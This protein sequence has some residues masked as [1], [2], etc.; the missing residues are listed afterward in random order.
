VTLPLSPNHGPKQWKRPVLL[1]NAGSRS[2]PALIDLT[3]STLETLGLPLLA[4]EL[5]EGHALVER[6]RHWMNDGADLLIVGGGDGTLR[7]TAEEMR[8]GET[9]LGILPLGTGNNFAR[10]LGL[11]IDLAGACKALVRG[12]TRTIELGE[13]EFD[14]GTVAVFVNAA[15]VGF[16]GQANPQITP[17]LKRRYGYFAYAIG[18]WRAYRAFAPFH[19]ALSTGGASRRWDVVQVSA[20]LGR[21]YAGGIG[22]IP[23]ETLQDRRMTL[24]VLE[25]NALLRLAYSVLH[26]ARSRHAKPARAHRYRL[27]EVRLVTDPPQEVNL[28]GEITGTTP[29]TFR[30]TPRALR[31]VA[32][33]SADA[34]L[35]RPLNPW[36]VVGGAAVGLLAG[37][38]IGRRLRPPS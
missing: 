31:V 35:S 13:A 22:E 11:P 34:A 27:K 36:L 15:H 33:G 19:L 3:R 10:D 28:D 23:G 18:G 8:G 38:W 37:L 14:D 4:A 1:V 2:G 30:V 5:V 7:L 21:T 17:H 12:E 32:G 16:F 25:V 6:L 20:I 26:I 9:T 24:T 29:V